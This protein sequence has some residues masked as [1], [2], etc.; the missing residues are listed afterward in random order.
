MRKFEVLFD[1]GEPSPVEDAAYQPYGRL[2]FPAPP[3]DRPWI[4]SNFVQSLDGIVSF[5]GKHAAGADISRSEEDR[6]LMDLLR[7]HADAVII[8]VNTLLDETELGERAR[9]PVFRIMN[10]ELRRLRQRLGTRR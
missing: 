5:K 9:G 8:G 3:A 7:A 6:W 2:G 4:F 1:E 10:E